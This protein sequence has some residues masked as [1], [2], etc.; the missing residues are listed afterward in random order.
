MAYMEAFQMMYLFHVMS[1]GHGENN[2]KT[3]LVGICVVLILA[4]AMGAAVPDTSACSEPKQTGMCFALFYRYYFNSNTK[5][6]EQFIY[7]G[8]GGNENNFFTR[9]ECE[10]N[11]RAYNQ[12]IFLY[13]VEIRL[14]SNI[15]R[16][17]C[18]CLSFLLA[19]SFAA[20]LTTIP[21]ITAPPTTTRVPDTSAC[22]NPKEAGPCKGFFW[23]YYFDNTAMAC[24]KFVYG[25]CYGND[26]NF[27]TLEQCENTCN[28]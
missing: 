6:C 13:R 14:P 4:T 23:R 9:A 22:A 17:V 11:V 3:C 7:G 26:N 10:Q 15:M 27:L 16:L 24:L 2:M 5:Q 8:C 12:R 20:S 25:G 28:S 21:N 19:S 18:V 1:S